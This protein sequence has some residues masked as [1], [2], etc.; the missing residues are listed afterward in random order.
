MNQTGVHLFLDE[1]L[2]EVLTDEDNLLHTIAIDFVPIATEVGIA[3]QHHFEFALRHS[4]EPTA[5][6]ANGGLTASLL[7]HVANILFV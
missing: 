1:G 3:L 4:S 7:E 2:V 6:I 5:G